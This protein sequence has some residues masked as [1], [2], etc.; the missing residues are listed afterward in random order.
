MLRSLLPTSV[1]ILALAVAT[2]GF[3][4]KAGAAGDDV[5]TITQTNGSGNTA[6][7]HQPG[8][9]GNSA[10]ITQTNDMNNIAMQEQWRNLNSADLAIGGKQ[11][12][13]QTNNNPVAG[14]SMASQQDNSFG[15]V[16]TATQSNNTIGQDGSTRVTQ[17]INSPTGHNNTQTSTQTNTSGSSV[18]QTIGT[19]APGTAVLNY[20]SQTATQAGQASSFITQLI[21][22]T[23]TGNSQTAS[24]TGTGGTTASG[25]NENL[26][27][28]TILS[29]NN[30]AQTANITGSSVANT[31]TQMQ[32]AGSH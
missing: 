15:A 1:S 25:S 29:S 20:R 19:A 32:E 21:D 11:T 17:I 16:Q 4:Q 18:R 26:I 2:L 13:T 30:N 6:N 31:I 10:T 22:G 14:A 5:A 12:I 7:Q 23:G 27:S 9:L 3:A 8:N 28:Q 24:Q